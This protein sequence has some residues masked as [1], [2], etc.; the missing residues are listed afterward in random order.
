[1]LLPLVVLAAIT[2]V[3]LRGVTEAIDDVVQEAT[4]E[5]ATVLRL[6]ILIQ[7][8]MIVAH[9]GA[10]L[11]L[12]A[13]GTRE[14]IS[15]ANQRVHQAFDEI[16]AGPFALA[17]ERALVA[18]A[19]EEWRIGHQLSQALLADPGQPDG[20]A[21]VRELERAHTHHE[22]A[23]ARL[24]EVRSLSQAEMQAQL[25]HA[26]ALRRD[27]L[28]GIA[29]VFV[30]G[31][32]VASVVGTRLTRSILTPLR[33][34]ETAVDRFGTGDLSFRVPLTGQD[35]LAQL[36]G[37]LNSMADKLAQSQATL[38]EL[39][40]HDPLTGLINYREFHRQLTEEEERFRRYGRPFS[41]L[42][43]D[44]DHFK[45]INDTYGHLAG[46]EALRALAALIQG[47]VRPTDLAARYGGEEFVMVLP[48]TTGPAALVLAERLRN[49]V[50]SQA[51]PLSAAQTISLTVSIGLASC[52][53]DADSLQ[54]L[55]S[56]ADQALY[57]AKASGRNR[58]RR[59]GTPGAEW[60]GGGET[61]TA[62]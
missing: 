35:E 36:G 20:R 26:V 1:M 46:D 51:I 54:K 61:P 50:A 32:G 42:M 10:A 45:G 22:R 39:S 56:A 18:S 33:A 2:F 34:L 7:R 31:L 24:E 49:R 15:Q 40:T 41:L 14:Q 62:P 21:L 48:E 30:V 16:G 8:A 5:M 25:A 28:F 57:V 43:L 6:Q 60:T 3:S 53:E 47:E 19:Q 11:G 58:V 29:S 38:R 44:V 4:Q 13:P 27:V 52:P 12:E 55:I 59:S 17:E 9:D 37:T 23:L